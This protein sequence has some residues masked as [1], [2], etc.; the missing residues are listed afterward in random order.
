MMQAGF[1]EREE[2]RMDSLLLPQRDEFVFNKLH[3]DVL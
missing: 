2:P 3:G 1:I